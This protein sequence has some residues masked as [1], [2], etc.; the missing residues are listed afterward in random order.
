MTVI[1]T[2]LLDSVLTE[3]R[4]VSRFHGPGECG[5]GRAACA[6]VVVGE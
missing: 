5:A 4:S 1:D 2:G 6:V 3:F